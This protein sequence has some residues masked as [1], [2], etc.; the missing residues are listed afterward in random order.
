MSISK[1]VLLKEE[2][3]CVA[4]KLCCVADIPSCGT[5]FVL[6]HGDPAQRFTSSSCIR[7]RR[8]PRKWLYSLP[9]SSQ[10]VLQ[11][12]SLSFLGIGASEFVVG[13]FNSDVMPECQ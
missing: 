9:P 10:P 12:S 8:I 7:R 6:L 4:S 2:K 13:N 11:A 3:L 5:F 1:H